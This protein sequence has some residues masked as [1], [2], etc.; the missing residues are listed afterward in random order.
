METPVNYMT[1]WHTLTGLTLD[2]ALK[3]LMEV[4]PG[5]AYKAVPGA[6][7]LT[8][9]DPSYLTEVVTD[10]FG[11]CGV[12]W[13]FEFDPA[14]VEVAEVTKINRS[15]DARQTFSALVKLLSVRYAYLDENGKQVMSLPIPSNG[16]SEND[17]RNYALRG[18]ITNA[19]GASFAK[20]L[21]QLPVYQGFI[22][23]RNAEEIYRKRQSVHGETSASIPGEPETRQK[24]R[25]LPAGV[26]KEEGEKLTWAK[27]RVILEGIG[28]P[29][30]GKNLG[31]AQSDKVYG[32]AILKYL[33]GRFPNASGEFFTP[34]NED[35]A[36]LQVAAETLMEA[37]SG[38][39][40][41]K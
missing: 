14:S 1:R 30:A 36:R 32:S 23:H 28:V 8:D 11:A 2:E 29:L 5:R 12:G 33:S 13:V 17:N 24:P 9:I 27:T 18:A 4:L 25:P 20:L 16:G 31:D 26:P 40:R 41:Q 35:Q 38:K 37:E 34:A 22:D 10:V 21:W 7:G 3:R 39:S 15:G 19:I 6:A